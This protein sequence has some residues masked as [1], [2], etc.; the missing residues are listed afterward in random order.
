MI[1]VLVRHF[2]RSI[3]ITLEQWGTYMQENMSHLIFLI[4]PIV[5]FLFII[6]LVYRIENRAAREVIYR[7][8]PFFKEAV[9][10]FHIKLE[11]L[12]TRVDALED[13]IDRIENKIK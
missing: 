2:A 12:I 7:N 11:Y 10:S 3:I 9:D 4:F 6:W 13:K 8:F 1:N 5:I